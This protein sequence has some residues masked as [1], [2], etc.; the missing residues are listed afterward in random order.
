MTEES[1]LT[2]TASTGEILSDAQNDRGYIM[3]SFLT[4]PNPNLSKY[5]WPY[6]HTEQVI[7]YTHYYGAC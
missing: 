7:T 4:S 3:A 1:L 5:D 2:L 6:L